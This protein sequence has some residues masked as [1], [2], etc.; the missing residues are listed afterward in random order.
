MTNPKS[1]A[2]LKRV[3]VYVDEEI[4]NIRGFIQ[5]RTGVEMTYVQVFNHLIH[6]Y[7]K[8]A[9]EPRTQWAPMPKKKPVG[10]AT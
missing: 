9:N 10:S 8:H 2:H 7:M 4:D 5:D 6:F 3:T 1:K